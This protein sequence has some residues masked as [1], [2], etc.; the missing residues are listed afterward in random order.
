MNWMKQPRQIRSTQMAKMAPIS[1]DTAEKIKSFSTTG[2]FPGIPW[3]SPMPNH[4]PVPMAKRDWV[5]WY[6]LFSISAHGLL[7]AATLR[8]TWSNSW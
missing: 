5:I 2:I 6:P 7:Q 8:R 1:S 4:P 3:Q